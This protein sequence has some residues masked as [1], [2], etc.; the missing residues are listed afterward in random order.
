[1][2]IFVVY[3]HYDWESIYTRDQL[4]AFFLKE[5]AESFLSEIRK[6]YNDIHGEYFSI[7]EIEVDFGK[8]TT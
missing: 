6:K 5:K 3:G 2:K 4:W 8:T 1:M 7:K